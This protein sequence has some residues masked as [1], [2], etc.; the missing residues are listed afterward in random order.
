MSKLTDNNGEAGKVVEQYLSRFKGTPDAT[1]LLLNMLSE[2]I[3][4]I[5]HLVEYIIR[6]ECSTLAGKAD[7]EKDK[8]ISDLSA[9]YGISKKRIYSILDH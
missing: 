7:D 8:I 9:V 2:N 4:D 5:D 3:T 1:R 6:H